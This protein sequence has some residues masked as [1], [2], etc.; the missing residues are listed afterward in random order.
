MPRVPEDWTG[1]LLVIDDGNATGK[2]R[3]LLRELW[4]RAGWDDNDVAS[5]HAVRCSGD[6]PSMA[7]IRACRPFLLQAIY[8]LKPKHILA[9]GSTALRALRN[10]GETNLT[11]NRGKEIRIPG[12]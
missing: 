12:L 2:A 6:S 11:K 9:L 5:V 4:R 1:K 3:R 7:Q 8:K 10:D